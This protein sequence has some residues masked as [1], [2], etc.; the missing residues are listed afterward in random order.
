M[1]TTTEQM[2]AWNG[3][4]ILTF[5]F[6]PF[7]FGAAVWAVL[8]MALWV[9]MLSGHLMLPTT[10]DPV[11]WHAHEFLFGYLGAVVAGFLLTAVP[12]WTGRLPIVGWRLG[13]LAGLW[14]VGRVA[15]A[16]SAGLPDVLVAMADLAFP[17]VFAFLIAREIVAGKNWRN[18]VVLAMLGVFIL[19]NAFFHWEAANGGYAAQG[20]GLRLGLGAGIMMIAVIGGRVVPSFTRNWLVKRRGKVLPAPPMQSFDKAALAVLAVAL[21]LWVALPLAPLTGAALALAGVLHTLR[22]ARW[23]GHRTFAEPLVMVLHTGY[24]FVPLGSLAL[25][26]EILAPGFFGMAGAQH[27]WLAGAVGLMTLAVMTRA[28]L[29]HTG[30][31]L[32]AGAGTVTIYLALILS[33]IARVAGGV[34]P[35]FSGLLNTVAGLFWILAFGGFAVLYGSLLLRLPAAKRI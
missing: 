21:V 8:A 4:A 33:V 6:R 31:E 24:A 34:W 22:L 11:S 20:Y 18:L 25:A 12:N 19:G 27:F 29:G 17:V 7:F 14:L 28:T 35:E 26:A 9:P 16:V 3:P 32:R 15:V 23:A 2:R 5:G 1:T 10:F 13:M 30:Q